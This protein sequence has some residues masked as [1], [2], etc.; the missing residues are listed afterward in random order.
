MVKLP[1]KRLDSVPFEAA[2]WSYSWHV[3]GFT[4]ESRSRPDPAP[5]QRPH[6]LD[7]LDAAE[8]TLLTAPRGAGKT[9]LLD[10][11][12][13]RRREL[14]ERTAWIDASTWGRSGTDARSARVGT[15]VP[16][17]ALPPLRADVD[18]LVIDGFDGSAPEAAERLAALLDT[19]GS[20]ARVAIATRAP[21]HRGADAHH[22]LATAATLRLRELR[23]VASELDAVLTEAHGDAGPET[24]ALID[25]LTGGLPGLVAVILDELRYAAARSLP[26]PGGL[27]LRRALRE[28][29]DAQFACEVAR[30]EGPE[31][32]DAPPSTGPC[33]S[34]QRLALLPAFG[35]RDEAA[36][37]LPGGWTMRRL[38][39]EGWLEGLSGS[40]ATARGRVPQGFRSAL[41]PLEDGI[42]LPLIAALAR[43]RVEEDR[44][45]EA[46]DIAF[47]RAGA[48]VAWS[49]GVTAAARLDMQVLFRIARD[50]L[51][52]PPS[53]FEPSPYLGWFAA[54]F[55]RGEGPGV[56]E[57]IRLIAA[58]EP[59]Q[60]AM[61]APAADRLM[62]FSILTVAFRIQGNLDR[63]LDCADRSIAIW[64]NLS[65]T[66]APQDQGIGV[67]GLNT[68]AMTYF[69]ANR[70]SQAMACARS[71]WEITLAAGSPPV[72]ALFGNSLA[73]IQAVRGDL[74]AAER[75]IAAVRRVEAEQSPR[76][77]NAPAPLV[78]GLIA[79]ERGDLETARASIDAARTMIGDS[80]LWP[81][82]ESAA[83]LVDTVAQAPAAA[84]RLER[85]LRSR[86]EQGHRIV[87]PRYVRTAIALMRLVDPTT[88]DTETATEEAETAPRPGVAD[89]LEPVIPALQR[90]LRSDPGGALRLARESGQL[91]GPREAPRAEAW[92]TLIAAAA[93][94]DSGAPSREIAQ[95]L[96]RAALA[97]ESSHLAL[98]VRFI[99]ERLR[100]DLAEIARE[101]RFPAF[102]EQLADVEGRPSLVSELPRIQTPSQREF[103]VLRA[104]ASDRSVQ[105]IA[106]ELGVSVN[107]AKTQIQR[108]YRKLGAHT[109]ADAVRA[110]I[111]HGLID[112]GDE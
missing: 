23:F 63:A 10:R 12:L 5:L 110:A 82:Y 64:Q 26:L 105:S 1:C 22:R 88:A 96:A 18:A 11:W 98:Q 101:H 6:L 89:P 36:L 94:L 100:L 69:A 79:L 99:P 19:A 67:W 95:H 46:W 107:T 56:T 84:A 109:R 103:E 106:D 66:L 44:L 31:R 71:A 41:P 17:D 27:Q 16:G 2:S 60:L 50:C 28:D 102:A 108:L 30:A 54:V 37:A 40:G 62:F 51:E 48:A 85:A 9:V 43:T 73:L 90:L 45:D 32:L 58:M 53:W 21:L 15:G 25:A 81:I 78:A 3:T 92:R 57:R 55:T 4:D 87:I 38:A 34:L 76:I 65:R 59:T 68:A 52:Q 83:A 61:P 91:D 72:S 93:A 13:Q 35:L 80:E 74:A 47:P 97:A 49:I 77:M 112:G 7:R 29:L 39:R 86:T 20:A 24:T 14:G 70:Q 111:R 75:T 104:L 42:A 8:T 33:A